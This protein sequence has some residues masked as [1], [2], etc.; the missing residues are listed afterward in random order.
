MTIDPFVLLRKLPFISL[1]IGRVC[2][3]SLVDA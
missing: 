2:E 1:E 3:L